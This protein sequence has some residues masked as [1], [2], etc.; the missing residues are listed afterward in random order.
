MRTAGDIGLGYHKKGNECGNNLFYDTLKIN[1]PLFGKASVKI[2][3][4]IIYSQKGALRTEVTL[5]ITNHWY[6][7][8]LKS[9][10]CYILYSQN[11]MVG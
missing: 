2:R 1:V 9:S 6:P 5:Y 3:T 4:K 10:Y 8:S 7:S 11:I